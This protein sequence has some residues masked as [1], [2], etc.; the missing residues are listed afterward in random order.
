MYPNF[1][2]KKNNKEP[3]NIKDIKKITNNQDNLQWS[4]F[5]QKKQSSIKFVVWLTYF[6][7]K[8][9]PKCFNLI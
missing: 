6:S 4:F 8:T 1:S 3:S 2:G 9:R 5:G 7:L